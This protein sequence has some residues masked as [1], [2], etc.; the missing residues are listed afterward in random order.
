MK[1]LK[2]WILTNA[3]LTFAIQS[4]KFPH[5]LLI[6][7]DDQGKGDVGYE[8]NSFFSP[9]IDKLAMDGLNLDRMYSATT[10][11]PTR[12]ALLTGKYIN[13]IGLQDGAYIPGENRTLSLAF[14]L[15]PEYLK[16]VGYKTM[17]IGKWHLGM[18]KENELPH[19]RGFDEWFGNLQGNF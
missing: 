16:E 19:R 9:T 18:N 10:C 14:K 8:D 12:G 1:L 4:N 6:V 3:T 11:S 15:L 5:I 13:N 7:A 17:G 2:S